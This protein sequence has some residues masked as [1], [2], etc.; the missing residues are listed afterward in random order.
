MTERPRVF[1]ARAIPEAGLRLVREAAEAEIWADELPPSRGV[2]LEEVRG[3]DGLLSLLTDRVDDELL[4]AAGPRLKVVSNFAVGYDNIDVPACTRAG[5]AVGNT[6]GVLT[7]TTA[8]LAFAL[9]MSAARR[10]PEGHDYVR[11][12]HWQT[13]GP[14]LLLGK[15]IHGATLGL[16][17]FGRIGREMARRAT[18]F[19][20]RTLYFDKHRADEA[21]ERD[22]GVTYTPLERV[23]AEADFLSL[24]TVLSD[25]THHLIDAAALARMKRGAILINTS[26]GPVVDQDAL[27]VALR[28]GQLFAAGLD[29]TDPE[30]LRADHPLVQLPN[31]LIVPHIASASERTRDRM[32]EKAARNLIAGIHGEA[33]P[34]PVTA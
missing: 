28:S 13:W 22:L 18:G 30:P 11:D 21:T 6:P 1:V 8:D 25:E 5:V 26:R 15:D 4:N 7:E 31:C 19:G 12:D 24:H 14:M 3:V 9:L 2:L 32:A 29:V 16:I 27:A 17:G 33:L 34:D 10:L 23:L 20:M